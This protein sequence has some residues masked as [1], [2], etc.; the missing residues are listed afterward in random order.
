[1]PKKDKSKTP[2]L[3]KCPDRVLAIDPGTR[4]VGTAIFDGQDLIYEN[5]RDYRYQADTNKLLRLI[6]KELERLVQAYR[7]SMIVLE[8]TF[9][10]SHTRSARSTRVD[11]MIKRLAASHGTPV[12]VLSAR[13][14]RWILLGNGNA[15]KFELAQEICR[16]HPRLSIYLKQRWD[17]A[18]THW[19]NLFDAVAVGQA[20][21]VREKRIKTLRRLRS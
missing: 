20:Y 19:S 3:S 15:T 11:A 17:Y 8:K 9:F 10:Y 13:T 14:I 18:S 4:R 1:M 7:P 2:E 21:L 12:V 6:S 5:A 16:Y